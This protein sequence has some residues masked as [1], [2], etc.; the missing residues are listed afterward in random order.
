MAEGLNV[1]IDAT[2]S[3]ISNA[4]GRVT[5][6]VGFGVD[7]TPRK[8]AEQARQESELRFR[9]VV[10]N[11]REVFWMTDVE[12]SQMLYLSPGYE[13]IWGRTCESAYAHPGELLKAIH[14]EDRE[15]IREASAKKQ[16]AGTYDEEYRIVR[17]DNG[18]RWIRDRAFPVKD[19][20]GLVYRIAGVAEDITR[21]K[22]L[23][24]QFRQSQKMEAVGTL[25]GGVAH[26]F[27]NILGAI[28]G[29]TELA[30][31]DIGSDHPAKKRLEE[32]RKASTRARELVQQILAF[33]RQQNLER[34]VLSL[35]PI[36]E[37]VVKLLRAS[38]PANIE[39]NFTADHST[40]NV[41]ANPTQIHQILLNLCTNAWHAMS[42]KAGRI[43]IS[44]GRLE[45]VA[46]SACEDLLPGC[47]ASL[48]V[49]DNG[50]GM[51]AAT[52]ERIFDP[53][54]TTKG[55]GEGTGLGLAVVH[56]IVKSH[57]ATITVSSRPAVGTTFYLYFPAADAPVET[58]LPETGTP[59]QSPSLGLRVL[60]LDDEEA[61]VF[62]GTQILERIGCLVRGFS[63]ASEAL[64]AFK[65][66]PE[67]FDV[68]ITDFNMPTMSG[69]DVTRELLAIRP[70]LPVLLTSGYIS[71]DLR[72]QATMA[73]VSQLIAKPTTMDEL[74]KAINRVPRVDLSA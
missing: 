69:L 35:R 5:E 33:S 18:V 46:Q 31:Q 34:R 24:A 3:P 66:S 6:L 67:Q 55:P 40:P 43:E 17:P 71:D 42:G 73:G 36:I 22:G 4:D 49:G 41:L 44:L 48:A 29:N 39:L 62:V 61:L 28:M 9:Q 30:W 56:G 45:V 23:E 19:S 63:N 57:D 52:L 37:E 12:T 26:D 1:V 10:E 27:N 59:K 15:R 65:V 72:A 7:I 38:L 70:E 11:I 21:Q 60:Y 50:N 14:P 58:T 51:D 25:A 53:F 54:F 20:R 47:Y 16:E 64:D 8:R 68:A 74:R 32:I 2:F 13:G